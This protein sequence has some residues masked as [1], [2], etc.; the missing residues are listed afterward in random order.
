MSHPKHP[1]LHR[2]SRAAGAPPKP[3]APGIAGRLLGDLDLHLI[4]EGQHGNLADCLG[5]H[6]MTI[7]GEQ[8]K[9]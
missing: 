9:L 2:R 8:F 6:A 1:G 7:D 5:A 4:A 3:T